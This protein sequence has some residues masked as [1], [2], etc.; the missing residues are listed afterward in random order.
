M[1]IK[2]THR[3]AGGV[4]PTSTSPKRN[5]LEGSS[6]DEARAEKR[7]MEAER[8]AQRE[9]AHTQKQVQEARQSA[10]QEIDK[11]K[12]S[13]DKQSEEESARLQAALEKQRNK[14]YEALRELKRNQS[15]EFSKAR[16]DGEADLRKTE[17]FLNAAIESAQ[18]RKGRELEETRNEHARQLTY[19][20][21][22]GN[23]A[24]E[25]LK[26]QQ[27][28]LVAQTR[29]RNEESIAQLREDSR[30]QY[31]ELQ[32]STTEAIER[33]NRHFEEKFETTV[34]DQAET[35]ANLNN[36]ASDQIRE[37]R[38]ETSHKLAGYASRQRDP[39]YKM[40]ELD[41]K[42]EDTGEGY[43]LTARIP[44]HE[45]KNV[46]VSL[47]GNQ[48]VV[49]GHRR[50]EE[51]LE[52]RPGRTVG[53]NSYQSF[54]EAFPLPWPV[55]GKQLTRSFDGDQLIVTVPKKQ[56]VYEAKVAQAPKTR[57][58]VEKPRFPEN[59][60]HVE[61]D[62]AQVDAQSDTPPNDPVNSK[63]TTGSRTLG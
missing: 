9:I 1:E 7:A 13:Y 46:S 24:I 8:S 14:G 41:L 25:E 29:E 19:E 40:V 56:M 11:I 59:I 52:L 62:P 49:S 58:K 51:K 43:L 23:M 42:V 47:K 10:D 3:P 55:D 50:N 4:S 37:I 34:Q 53:T 12:L 60:P 57:A 54:H 35:I 38:K 27:N 16:R 17:S 32:Q 63:K 2:P 22:H 45:Q 18:S 28:Y 61:R 21:N 15:Q 48:L 6:S 5:A 20:K 30:A 26:S 39:F 31:D 44:E 36:R 33:A